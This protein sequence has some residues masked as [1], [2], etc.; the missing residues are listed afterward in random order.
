MLADMSAFSPLIGPTQADSWPMAR[1]MAGMSAVPVG[2]A[3]DL[4]FFFPDEEQE[5]HDALVA[6]TRRH[7]GG[8]LT[9]IEIGL[10]LGLEET[11][12]IAAALAQWPHPVCWP[13]LCAQPTL[14]GP[15]LL[16]HMRMRGG[17]SLMLRQFG[18]PD[19]NPGGESEAEALF[20]ADDP[21][22]GDALAALMLA[23]GRWLL[24]GAD[25]QPMLPDLPAHFFSELLWTAAASLAAII[26]RSGLIEP[27]A[28]V[29]LV[30]AAAGRLLMRH[31][32]AAGPIAAADRLVRQLGERADAPE[33]MGAALGQRRF[34]LFA[35]LAGRRL[36]MESGQAADI[37]VTGPMAH[38]AAL[39]RALGGS[40]ADYRHLLLALRPV[41]PS[42]S[43]SAIVGEAM[44]Y[45]DLTVAQADA[46]MNALRAPA[47]LR[48]RLDHLRRIGG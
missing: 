48:A 36:R 45:Q 11:P 34:L 32:E 46:V 30:E 7:L 20:P 22:L 5:R 38:V 35:A 42:L 23:E 28:V 43:D 44:R 1:V 37:L 12:E 24:T 6:E 29:P 25:D 10:R 13:T 2:H 41:R 17:I 3:I 14:L 33:L 19:G 15:A 9:A 40:D 8:C 21:A 31:D 16:A 4:A 39:C 27:D 47:A 26:Q 18:G